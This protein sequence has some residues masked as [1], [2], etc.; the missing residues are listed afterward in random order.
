MCRRNISAYLSNPSVRTFLGAD[1][2][3]VPETFE[4]CSAEVGYLFNSH[5]D[6]TGKTYLYVSQLLE[7]GIKVRRSF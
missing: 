5:M 4:G 3:L 7:R 2:P 6:G 1:D